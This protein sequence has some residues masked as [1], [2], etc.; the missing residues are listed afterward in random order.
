VIPPARRKV[1]TARTTHLGIRSL[2]LD[3]AQDATGDENST[4]FKSDASAPSFATQNSPEQMLNRQKSLNWLRSQ[5]HSDTFRLHQLTSEIFEPLEKLLG[6]EKFLM[7][8]DNPTSLDYL[9]LGYLSLMLYAPVSQQW[10]ADALKKRYPKLRA[11]IDRMYK[12]TFKS[13][14]LKWTERLFEASPP[15]TYDSVKFIS[16]HILDWA[17]P[18]TQTIT[19]DPASKLEAST[20]STSI[21]P[22]S[23]FSYQTLVWSAAF[24]GGVAFAAT[25]LIAVAPVRESRFSTH[26][27]DYMQPTKL[28]DLGEAGASLATLGYQ[29]DLKAR[30]RE[31]VGGATIMEVDVE[32]D[33]G[34]VGRQ[35][36]VSK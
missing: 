35:V 26:E 21:S 31:R 19:V 32:N 18:R 6:D 17:S 10:L 4:A 1:A 36:V 30:E 27:S 14:D 5:T 22:V 20:S 16:H 33:S 8:T 29:I 25:R 34:E 15:T 12:H 28:S 11:Y 23:N 13:V 9:A 2:D 7:T 3:S 24:I